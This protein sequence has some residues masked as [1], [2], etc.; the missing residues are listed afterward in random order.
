MTLLSAWNHYVGVLL[1]ELPALAVRVATRARERVHAALDK[2]YGMQRQ[3]LLA[4]AHVLRAESSAFG[5]A[6]A[7]ALRQQV[8][9]GLHKPADLPASD[10]LAERQP[11]SLSLMDDQQVE[12]DIEL[13]R[14]IQLI[15]STAEWELR[16][17]QAFYASL[18]RARSIRPEQ[19]PL[20]PEM[21]ASALLSTLQEA[22]LSHEARVL[23]LHV[24]AQPL[25]DALRELYAEHCGLLRRSGVQAQNYRVHRAAPGADR[26]G[27]LRGLAERMTPRADRRH[28]DSVQPKVPTPAGTAPHD[29]GLPMQLIPKLLEQIADQAEM[30]ATMRGLLARLRVPVAR[31]A[32]AEAGV[33]LSLDHPVWRLVDRIASLSSVND[34]QGDGGLLALAELLEPIV[35]RLEQAEQPGTGV[36]QEALNQVGEATLRLNS[37]QLPLAPELDIDLT[38]QLPS[39]PRPETDQVSR[40]AYEIDAQLRRWV[41]ERL[42]GSNAP[43]ALRQFLLGPWVAVMA[44]ATAQEGPQS[45]QTLRWR[46]AVGEFIVQA[47]AAGRTG[48]RLAAASALIEL[49]AQ[50]MQ[51]AAIPPHQLQSNLVELRAVLL[52]EPAPDGATRRA[53]GGDDHPSTV[54]MDMVVTDADTPAKQDREAWLAQ[55]VPGDLCRLFIQ[56]RWMNAQLTWRSRNGQFCVFASRHGGRLHTLTRRQLERLRATGLATTVERGQQVRDAVDT[57]ARDIDE[58]D[59]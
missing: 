29:P 54:P 26:D 30:N 25:A 38:K 52:H 3:H 17:L 48:E 55:L 15:E 40:P 39:T 43:P 31:A 12:R 50:G 41:A 47:E 24:S 44:R 1:A 23:A 33:L 10:S 28:S 14:V 2:S 49:A 59:G 16:D 27:A 18:R 4:V 45:A 7:A 19:N 32:E 46:S 11:L 57:L 13:A 35:A 42:R 37:R 21:C 20:R 53:P 36:F 22:G 34:G 51:S 58:R 56:S 8:Q 6:L 5:D 9:A